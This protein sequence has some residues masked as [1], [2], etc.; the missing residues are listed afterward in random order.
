MKSRNTYYVYIIS[1]SRRTVF[2]IG[3][4]GNLSRRWFE[5][6]KKQHPKSFSA[7]YNCDTVVYVEDYDDIEY[8]IT[9]EKYLKG[10]NR[11]RKI[12]LIINQN[13]EMKNLLA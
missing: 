12:D 8:A 13:S 11:K 9:R 7:R 10:W 4:T 3:V 1:N 5:H 2:Y 6:Y